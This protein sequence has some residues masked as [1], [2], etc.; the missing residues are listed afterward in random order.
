MKDN[1][2]YEDL[3][4]N[5]YYNTIDKRSKDYREYKQYLKSKEDFKNLQKN[6]EENTT[7][8]LGDVVEKIAKA[9]GI[10]KVVDALVDDCGCDERKKK[11]NKI[12]LWKRRKVN[13]IEESDYPFVKEFIKMTKYPFNDRERFVKIYNYVFR[14]NVKNTN[15]VSCFKGYIKNIKKYLEIYEN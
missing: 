8:G 7:I 15:C 6:V 12:P 2:Y 1:K 5:G 13:C 9:T 4:K 10:K 3:E 11:F 14:V